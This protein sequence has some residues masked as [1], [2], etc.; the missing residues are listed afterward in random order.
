MAKHLRKKVINCLAN[1]TVDIGS[2]KTNTFQ[3]V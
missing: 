3:S 2:G 1:N